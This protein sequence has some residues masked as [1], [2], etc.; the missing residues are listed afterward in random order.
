[1]VMQFPHLR[2]SYREN[3]GMIYWSSH[4][5]RTPSISSLFSTRRFF[6][7]CRTRLSLTYLRSLTM[8]KTAPLTRP[9]RR[10]KS[11][12]PE[13]KWCTCQERC[14]GGKEVAASTYRSHNPVVRDGPSI[15][16]KRKI[17][18][19]DCRLDAESDVRE[20]RRMRARR[21]ARSGETVSQVSVEVAECRLGTREPGG[22]NTRLRE[23][24]VRSESTVL[25]PSG[26]ISCP[27][28]NLKAGR[29]QTATGTSRTMSRRGCQLWRST[30]PLKT[31]RR[32]TKIIGK[33]TNFELPCVPS[34][35]W[36][37]LYSP[38]TDCRFL[39]GWD[40]MLAPPACYLLTLVF[41]A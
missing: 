8:G 12:Q 32:S 3:S 21:I 23:R 35:R 9:G 14:G 5:S 10:V 25:S 6:V 22:V 16:S 17:V 41:F 18:D 15:G 28:T 4:S 30:T 39:L 26:L 24:E 1:M 36:C 7:L 27:R 38:G 29:P 40:P 31:E 13:R 33:M 34:T 2:P 20:T 11:K 37:M 19:E